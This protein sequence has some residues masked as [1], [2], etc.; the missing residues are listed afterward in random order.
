MKRE[1]R[2]ASTTEM[3]PDYPSAERGL[4]PGDKGEYL[5]TSGGLKGQR[6]FF[7]CGQ[8]GEVTGVDL[9]GGSIAECPRPP[10]KPNLRIKCVPRNYP[11]GRENH[12]S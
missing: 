9:G 11:G 12:S 2:A 5:I 3:P 8:S 4:L 1:I 6:G 7:R 10:D